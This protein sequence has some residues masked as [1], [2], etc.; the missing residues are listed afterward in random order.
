MIK[1][2]DK[3]FLFYLLLLASIIIRFIFLDQDL[4]SQRLTEYNEFDQ[5]LYTQPVRSWISHYNC[6]HD[7]V[8]YPRIMF[9]LFQ[10]FWTYPFLKI[11]GNNFYGFKIPTVLISIFII[12]ILITVLK[13]KNKKLSIVS[14]ILILIISFDFLFII[15]SRVQNPCIYSLFGISLIFYLVKIFIETKNDF[16][17]NLSS[18]LLGFFGIFI[19]L[20]VYVFNLFIIASISTFFLFGFLFFKNISLKEISLFLLGN[21]IGFLVYNLVT[22]L[23]FQKTFIDLIYLLQH[24]GGADDF[25]IV[26]QLDISFFDKLK[27]HIGG[28]FLLSFF[29]LNLFYLP[30]ILSGFSI[31]LLKFLKKERLA[32]FILIC[33]AFVNI[34]NWFEPH[35]TSKKMIVL[36]PIF[37]ILSKYSIDFI[38]NF[39]NEKKRNKHFFLSFLAFGFLG[40]LY[41]Y[42]MSTSNWYNDLW[43]GDNMPQIF[44]YLNFS[45]L[46]IIPVFLFLYSLYKKKIL[47]YPLILLCFFSSSFI[48]YSEIITNKTYFCKESLIELSEITQKSNVYNG[49]NFTLYNNFICSGS[50]LNFQD[51]FNDNDFNSDKIDYILLISDSSYSLNS[52]KRSIN[53]NDNDFNPLTFNKSLYFNQGKFLN[54]F[55]K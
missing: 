2:I 4:P 24:F 11:F 30:I 32:I 21:L 41:N 15:T 16:K 50:S 44:N 27:N 20:L 1:Y 28:L 49:N 47:F 54:I 53:L 43:F 6:L 45:L 22:F 52:F 12:Y 51:I 17:R 34:Q 14:M 7:G 18:L 42:K 48:I 10:N 5:F 25:R 3:N 35:Y 37:L 23:L 55:K 38:L 39:K 9:D 13:D 29:R 31:L 40:A 46:F 19:V 8:D 36:I 33:L 26:E